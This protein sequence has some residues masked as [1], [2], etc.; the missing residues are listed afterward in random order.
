MMPLILSLHVPSTAAATDDE[1]YVAVPMI[2]TFRLKSITFVPATA[3]ALDAA[4]IRIIT[5][6]KNDGAAGADSAALAAMTTLTGGVA[7][8]LKTPIRP[9]LTQISDFTLGQGIKVAATHGGTGAILDGV[10]FFEF[11]KMS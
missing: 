11:E 2:G 1:W 3:V 7:Y 8:V 5:F 6:T 4:N 9:A 10:F